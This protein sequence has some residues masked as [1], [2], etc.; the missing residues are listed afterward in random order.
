[1]EA[2]RHWLV[3]HGWGVACAARHHKQREREADAAGVCGGGLN[4]DIFSFSFFSCF[5][6][7]DDGDDVRCGYF[8]SPRF[9]TPSRPTC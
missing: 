6:Y 3:L 4:L 7:D 5:V 9:L 8:V 2:A 1:M